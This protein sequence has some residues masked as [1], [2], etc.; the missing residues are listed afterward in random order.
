MATLVG[1]R[2]VSPQDGATPR[3]AKRVL[4]LVGEE[5]RFDRHP[6]RP[7]PQ[8]AT[9]SI[10]QT[11]GILEPDWRDRDRET[12]LELRRAFRRAVAEFSPDVIKRSALRSRKRVD[13][14]A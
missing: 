2:Y 3:A 4:E 11:W 1:A 8:I 5:V 14:R 7:T 6:L 12:E 9:P 10:T 13:L